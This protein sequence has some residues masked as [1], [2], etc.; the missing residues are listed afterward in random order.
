[1][2]Y[3]AAPASKVDTLYLFSFAWAVATVLHSLSFADRIT[4]Q[5]P[6][7]LAAL[8]AA[9]LVI[10]LPQAIWPFLLMLCCSIGNTLEFRPF[11]PNHFT[12]ELLLN[13]GIVAA[14][15]WTIARYYLAQGPKPTWQTPALRSALLNS[16]APFVRIS[17]LLLY[18][19][20]VLHKLNRD[21]FNVT[22]SCSTFLL[23]EYDKRLP[24]LPHGAAV[25]W[26]AVWGTIAIEASIP[27]LLCFRAT[28]WAGI[29]LGFGFHYFLAINPHQGLYSFSAL[30]FGLYVLFVPAGF[31]AQVWLLARS[32]F[33]Q[34]QPRLARLLRALAA[35][36]VL[37][38][39]ALALS[40]HLPNRWVG[41]LIWLGWSLLCGVTYLL[42]LSRNKLAP[43]SFRTTFRVRPAAF[44][45]VPALV[46]FN[47]LNPYLGLNTE[48]SFSMFSNLR[49]E[50]GI[51]NHFLLT[52]PLQLTNFQQDLVEVTATNLEALKPFVASNQLLTY[53]EF[54]RAA[55]QAK[56][57]FYVNYLRNQRAQTVRVVHGVSS[58]PAVTTPYPWFVAKYFHFRP[59][60]KGPCSCKH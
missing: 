59:V 39:L 28:R 38:L 52:R 32:L 27:L 30:L 57:D 22:T 29:L 56:T 53:F 10:F 16:F 11:E 15:C 2:N 8:V 60:D 31:P 48:N 47:G 24:F 1:M 46:F 21:Y 5:H 51:S 54:R 7:A 50:G 49:T 4:T 34:A 3:P 25:N 13:A 40:G 42:V 6:F 23:G 17:L 58:Q 20:A 55:S 19:Y 26:A 33:G 36:G 43:E 9:A 37:G 44:W 18:F 41:M 12:F 35:S 45:L 14:L